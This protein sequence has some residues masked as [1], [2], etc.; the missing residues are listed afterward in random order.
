[1]KFV[2]SQVFLNYPF[3]DGFEEL[4][5]AMHF[6]VV[7]SNLIPICARD[8]ASP[9]RPRLE[10]LSD[11]IR[12]CQYSLHDFSILKPQGE[13]E[14]ARLN[15]SFEMGMAVFYALQ[16]Q[17]TFHRCAFF[18]PSPHDYKIAL[19]DVAGLDPIVYDGDEL[20]LLVRAYEWLRDVARSPLTNAHPTNDIKVLYNDFKR[21]TNEIV[22]S[23]NDHR[24]THNE[25]RE[26]MFQLC[27]QHSL[28]DWRSNKNGRIAFPE[29]PLSWR[30]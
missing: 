24:L 25:S 23:G 26:L 28:W 12:D 14:F 1:M 16:T 13:V 9:D 7:A 11:T 19:S 18:V 27:G 22:G 17:R 6:A 10:M 3:E 20:T 15:M 30:R 21:K 29:V 4:A 2:A 5:N 8:I